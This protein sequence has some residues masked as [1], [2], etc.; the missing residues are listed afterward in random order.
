VRED[1]GIRGAPNLLDVAFCR[2]ECQLSWS[3]GSEAIRNC[4]GLW[5]TGPSFLEPGRGPGH[6]L[7]QAPRRSRQ[8]LAGWP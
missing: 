6:W 4:I 2:L 5:N 3:E 1:L 8:R 7:L